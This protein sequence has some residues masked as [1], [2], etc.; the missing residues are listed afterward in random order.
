MADGQTAPHGD[1]SKHNRVLRQKRDTFHQRQEENERIHAAVFKEATNLG[2]RSDVPATAETRGHKPNK[3]MVT[4]KVSFRNAPPSQNI[5]SL[6]S[7]SRRKSV[8]IA[9]V[10]TQVS[11]QTAFEMRL[12][13]K[14]TLMKAN[15]S[16]KLDYKDE[17]LNHLIATDVIANLPSDRLLT[18]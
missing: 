9:E 16:S 17:I 2:K 6:E 14:A 13:G 4:S 7:V 15:R 11:L 5:Q 1:S 8:V 10:S 18:A 12:P 3:R